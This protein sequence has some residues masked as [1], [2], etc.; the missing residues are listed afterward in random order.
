MDTLNAAQCVSCGIAP[1][2]LA[3]W[4]NPIASCVNKQ[5]GARILSPTVLS[6]EFKVLLPQACGRLDIVNS[7]LPPSSS[8]LCEITGLGISTPLMVSEFMNGFD[9]APSEII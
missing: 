4:S 6:F 3:R 2:Y 9:G 5:N 7:N 1:F 8:W